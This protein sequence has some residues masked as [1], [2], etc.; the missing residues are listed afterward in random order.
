MNVPAVLEAK[1]LVSELME[2]QDKDKDGMLSF[3]E[4]PGPKGERFD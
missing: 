3:D 4:F 2:D 1:E